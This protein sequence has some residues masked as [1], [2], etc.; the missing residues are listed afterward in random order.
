MKYGIHNKQSG[1]LVGG[2][3]PEAYSMNLNNSLATKL[4][5]SLVAATCFSHFAFAADMLD[6]VYVSTTSLGQEETIED[7]QATVEVLDQKTIQGLSGRSVPQVLNE[8]AG[9]TVK[10]TGST[11]QIRMRGFDDGHTLI[12]V[13]GL[14]RTGAYGSSDLSG[15]MLEDVERIE[16]V[17]GPMSAL[18]GADALAGVV[19]IITKK[20]VKEDSAS[21]TIIGGMAQNGDRETGI[22]RGSANLGG[23]TISHAF[24]VEAKERDE[25]R[26]DQST[27]T[28]DLPA[29]SKQ[30]LSRK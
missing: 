3:M 13:D 23:E 30:F 1:H 15:I 22:V 4:S 28:T 14:R 25:Y 19:N 12:L 27:A 17:R 16:I 2:A 5:V 9:I 8:A 21:V 24:S 7:V 18:Y 11:S 20:A 29:E 26:L 10:D 6:P